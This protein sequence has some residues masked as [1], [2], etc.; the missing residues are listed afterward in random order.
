MHVYLIAGLIFLFFFLVSL[1]LL[2]VFTIRKSPVKKRLKDLGSET[3]A[4]DSEIADSKRSSLTK[5]LTEL[6][7][8][9][10]DERSSTSDTRLWLARAGYYSRHSVYDYYSAGVLFSILLG[11]VAGLAAY[12][13]RQEAPL[14]LLIAVAGLIVG[15]LLPRLWVTRLIIKRRNDIRRAVP[16][17]LDLMVVCV[18][19]GLSVTAA[20]RKLADEVSMNCQPLRDELRLLNHEMLLGKPKGEAFRSL[21]MR[22]GVDELRSLAITLIQTE[23]LGTSVAKS[24]RI[25]ADT[26]RFNRRQRAEELANKVS[27][28]LVFPLVLLIFPELLVVL[29]GPAVINLYRVFHGMV[30]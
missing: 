9:G 28:K 11:L 13:L 19:A 14:I 17:M 15:A 20:I 4:L 8:P 6:V 30:G 23:K 24:L 26:M 21:A 27:A 2:Y 16:N 29:V 5:N 7:I 3:E 25:L 18:E 1:V 22:T 12:Y 10:S